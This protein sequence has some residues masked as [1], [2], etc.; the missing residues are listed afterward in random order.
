MPAREILPEDGVKATWPLARMTWPLPRIETV[1][2]LAGF[3]PRLGRF[4]V[5]KMSDA[6][7]M[8]KWVPVKVEASIALK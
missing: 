4:E 3:T 2:P 6:S 5:R 1:S 7:E 8:V